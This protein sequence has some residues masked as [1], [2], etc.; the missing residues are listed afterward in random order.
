[1]PE[2]VELSVRCRQRRRMAVAEPD[3]GDAGEEIEVALPVG[4]DQPGAVAF[5]ERD[6]EPRVGRQELVAS[7]DVGHATTAVRPI[8]AVIPLAAARAAARSFGTMP[9]SKAP[10]AS[11]RRASPT[12]IAS[13]TSSST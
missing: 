9:P 2:P 4:V 5:D 1:M 12:P 7:C 11:M 13:T 3:D 10:S 8:V 6:V